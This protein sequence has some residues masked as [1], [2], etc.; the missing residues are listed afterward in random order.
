M[1]QRRLVAS[2]IE[3]GKSLGIKVVGE[4]VE[5]MAHVRIL[6]RLGCDILQGFALA[7][8]MPADRIGAFVREGAWKHPRG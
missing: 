8:P 2:I 5:T 4:G 6:R 7:R 3:M 1:E